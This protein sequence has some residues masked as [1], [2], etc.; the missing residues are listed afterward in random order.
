MAVASVNPPPA[1]SLAANKQRVLAL[2]ERARALF[3]GGAP[4]VAVA[5]YLAEHTDQIVVALF[6]EVLSAL[7]QGVREQIAAGS[8]IVAVGGTGRGELAPFSDIDL[9]FLSGGSD[10][11]QFRSAVNRAVQTYWDAGLKLGHAVRTVSECVTLA[12]SDPQIATSLI[13]ARRLWGSES[14]VQ[15]LT[16]RFRR[17]VVDCRRKQFIR[18]CIL[19]RWP[20]GDEGPP[21]QELEPDVKSSAGGLRD[22]HLIR[23]IGYALFESRDID[24]LKLVGELSPDEAIALREAWE[25]LTHVRIDLHFAAGK[26]QD[27]LTRDEQLRIT[28]RM[29]IQPTPTQRAVEVFM[30]RYFQH[31]EVIVRTARRFSSLSR[32]PSL[33]RRLHNFF[34]AHRADGV[35]QVGPR[36]IDAAPRHFGR[37]TKDLVSILRVYR[38]A[39]LYGVRPSRA[40][41]DAIARAVPGLSR[42][43][44]EPAAAMFMD[45]LRHP[46]PLPTLLRS[47]YETGLIEVL[48]PDVAHTRSLMQFNQYHQFTVDEHTLQAV[49]KCAAFEEDA[50]SLGA[51][52]TSIKQRDLLHLAVILHDIGKGFGRPHA[53]VGAEIA[54][55]VAKRLYLGPQAT[56]IV[57]RLVLRHLEMAHIAFRRDISDPETLMQFAHHLGTPEVLQMLYVLT[58]ADVQAVGPSAWTEW[59]AE[60]LG[61]LYDEA[62]VLLSGKHQGLHERERLQN[63]ARQVTEVLSADV[64][65]PPSQEDVEKQLSVFPASYIV[66]TLPNRIAG[67]VVVM[68]Q[69]DRQEVSIQGNFN[70][71]TST[72]DYR[73]ITA[74]PDMIPGCFHKLAGALT[75]RRLQILA[76]DIATT[77]NGFIVDSFRVHD[78]DYSEAPPP[79]RIRSIADSLRDVLLGRE[80]VTGLF[81]RNRRFGVEPPRTTF[82]DLPLRVQI[83]TESSETRTIIDVFA[84]DRPGL[85][86]TLSRTLFELGLSVDLA[87]IATN[88]DQ[89]VDVFY[90]VENDGRKVVDHE[91]VQQIQQT[92]FRALEEFDREGYREFA[93]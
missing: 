34:F 15:T 17:S 88:F 6:E 52:Y 90:V 54:E 73:I 83:D 37:I 81:R 20:D 40:L 33:R 43:V 11:D 64:P 31:A 79:E 44:S 59:K 41:E 61:G 48:I 36:E 86:F 53:E 25:F 50:G 47:L 42:G 7:P 77:S 46:R 8:A 26:A 45:I 76:A 24:S 87:K 89:V 71:E 3:D 13:E 19:A 55:R 30:Q 1:S 12:K 16:R 74:N 38:S 57:S 2:R 4:G 84:H 68:N 78:R 39:S 82:A 23:W 32:R 65:S 51:T 28:N 60:L 21:A 67:D 29:G 80:N 22:L 18:D 49:Q 85:L 5:I 70:P 9:L 72:V 56:E 27:R 93:N 14:L 62:M 91:R 92:L 66:N 10:V 69:L 35:F 58:A 63:A 75:A